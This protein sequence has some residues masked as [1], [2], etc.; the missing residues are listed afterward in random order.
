MG[1]CL[2]DA[3]VAQTTVS[4]QDIQLGTQEC[5][6]QLVDLKDAERTVATIKV[7]CLLFVAVNGTPA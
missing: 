5:E 1:A 6:F 3:T 7:R 4:I 2:E